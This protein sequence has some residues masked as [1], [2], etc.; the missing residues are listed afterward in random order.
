MKRAIFA[1]AILLTLTAPSFGKAGLTLAGQ[2]GASYIQHWN[3][4]GGLKF[5][6]AGQYNSSLMV[7]ARDWDVGLSV[8]RV[9][10]DKLPVK[11]LQVGVYGVNFFG[12]FRIG[13]IIS[14]D[15]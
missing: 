3:V 7:T 5:A 6:Y 11:S 10:S 9:L 8:T 12:D 14:L 2:V 15:L 1:A 13:G 4:A